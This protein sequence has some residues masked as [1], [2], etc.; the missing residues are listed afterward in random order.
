[1]KA[2]LETSREELSL[3]ASPEIVEGIMRVREGR[4]RIKCG[5]DGVYGKISIFDKGERKEQR[6]LNL[7]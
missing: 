5:Y 7:F 1:L 3:M 4:V 6:Q 2:L